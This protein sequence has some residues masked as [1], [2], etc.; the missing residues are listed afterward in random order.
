MSQ[1]EAPGVSSTGTV[2]N[3]K[4]SQASFAQISH[5]AHSSFVTTP[6]NTE[7]DNSQDKSSDEHTSKV[8]P[9]SSSS[10]AKVEDKSS[11][12]DLVSSEKPKES[13]PKSDED[14]AN[15]QEKGG[16]PKEKSNAGADPDDKST[17]TASSEP[18]R[19]RL[20]GKHTKNG[21][22]GKENPKVKHPQRNSKKAEPQIGNKGSEG[23]AKTLDKVEPGAKESEEKAVFKK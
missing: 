12:K 8:Q 19:K 2:A 4:L 3:V 5:K 14:K 22:G 10:K 7:G 11:D 17:K 6:N 15:D 16:A 18:G 23:P 1:A 21:D 20:R 13:S 9:E